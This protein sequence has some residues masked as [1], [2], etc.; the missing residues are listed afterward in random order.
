MLYSNRP[1]ISRRYQIADD[2]DKNFKNSVWS[3]HHQGDNSRM[4][5]D[6]KSQISTALTDLK[7]KMGNK[8]TKNKVRNLKLT[9][10]RLYIL[11][12]SV[13][14]L[15]CFS[16]KGPCRNDVPAQGGGEGGH[17]NGDKAKQ[18]L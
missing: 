7:N 15:L 14:W 2:T 13:P 9:L 8:Q 10:G 11:E 16:D 12:A 1:S 6:Y 18:S 3:G 5:S 17:P 4:P